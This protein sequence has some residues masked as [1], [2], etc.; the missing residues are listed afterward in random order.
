MKNAPGRVDFTRF[1]TIKISQKKN[2]KADKKSLLQN[3]E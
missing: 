2:N 3:I 1:I